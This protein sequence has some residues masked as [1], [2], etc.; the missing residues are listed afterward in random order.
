MSTNN[1]SLLVA[2]VEDNPRISQLIKQE[3][4]DEGH[5]SIGFTTAE[6]F[7][8]DTENQKVDLVLLDLMLP[9][10]DG[11][12]CLKQLHQRI[13]MPRVI[14]VTAVN[15]NEKRSQALA[16]GAEDYILKPNLFEILP[17]LLQN[18]NKKES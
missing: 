8:R 15:D 10:M 7:L 17:S 5:R 18:V 12:R 13:V 2:V 1:Q 4:K 16:N 14:I 6:E 3:I 9:G 11:L